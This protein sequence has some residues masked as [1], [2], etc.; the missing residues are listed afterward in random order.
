M[1]I[2]T[3]PAWLLTG[4]SGTDSLE[5]TEAHELPPLGE[6]DV[7]VRIHAASLNYRE[8][9][10]AKGKFNLPFTPPV[11][12]GSDGAG[13]ILATG[14]SVTSFKKGDRIVTHLTVNTP[15]NGAT[16]FADINTGL[17][18]KVDGTIRKY[19]VFDVS[20]V[21]GMP[22][23]LSFA[24]AAT[25]TCSGLTAWNAL[26]GIRGRGVGAGDVVLVQGTGG[27]SVAALQFALASGATVIATT[28]SDVKAERLKVLG[29]Q[30]VI[31]YRTTP[32]WGEVAK[33]LT[34]DNRGADVVVDVGGPSTV[35]QSLKAVRTDGLIAL[36]GLLGVGTEANV[37]SIMDGLTY[38]C[39]TRGFLL[40]S[41][42]Q[43]REMNRFIDH[44]G[45]KPVVDEKVFSFQEVREAFE[46]V[47]AQK[48][49]S[50]VVIE[51]E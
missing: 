11:T 45:I 17:G 25:L 15:E 39:T 7:L 49:F 38:L 10:I 22:E 9:L 42:V 24:E 35:A 19:G 13:I 46:Y 6:N 27:V 8:L 50:K 34:P 23:S 33:S 16:T 18:Q 28:S 40:G 32:N 30:H 41:R 4:Q 43:F 2:I 3:T 26:F 14:S 31:N 36:A 51:I 37:P 21:V 29:A 1:S 48:H 47:D 20:S 5:F 12:P 44:K